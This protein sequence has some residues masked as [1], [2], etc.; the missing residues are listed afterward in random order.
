VFNIGEGNFAKSTLL[1]KINAHDYLGASA[2]FLKWS[3]ANGKVMLGLTRR[4]AAERD[5]FLRG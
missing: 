3:K 4:R 1:K 5:H 2:E